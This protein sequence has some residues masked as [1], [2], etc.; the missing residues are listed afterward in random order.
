MLAR[1]STPSA[2]KVEL[3][4]VENNDACRSSLSA[5]VVLLEFDD[6]VEPD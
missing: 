1:L 5:D 4:K 2:A 3:V 6:T